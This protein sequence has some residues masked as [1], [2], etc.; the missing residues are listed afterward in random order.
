[1]HKNRIFRYRLLLIFSAAPNSWHA[2]PEQY[3]LKMFQDRWPFHSGRNPATKE[4]VSLYNEIHCH[5][6]LLSDT[7]SHPL[8][9]ISATPYA[10]SSALRFPLE[11]D[12]M[13]SHMQYRLFH[14]EAA[15]CWCPGHPS[16][17]HTPDIPDS[18]KSHMPAH[19]SDS[20][21]PHIC[22]HL[23]FVITASA[24]IHFLHPR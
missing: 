15:P 4:L 9:P 1:M 14:C 6:H 16:L 8:P 24:G 18:K 19:K 21:L 7:G 22:L 23:R 13:A 12:G 17:L 20:P 11:T 10:V 5:G 2:L 3:S